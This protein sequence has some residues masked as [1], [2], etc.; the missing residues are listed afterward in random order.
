M[1]RLL[2]IGLT[3]SIGTGKSTVAQLLRQKGIPVIDADAL[4][5][6]LQRRGQP[7]W[8]AVWRL[9]G[10][11]YLDADGELLRRKLGRYVFEHPRAREQLNRAIHPLV[12]SRIAEQL[13]DY[14]REG[15]TAVVVDVPL[16]FEAGWEASF[17][18]IWVVAAPLPVQ[19]ARLMR[20]DGLSE[21][22]AEARILAQWPLEEK[23]RR[24]DRVL[25][26]SGS[27][28]QLRD[29]VE[30]AWREVEA[31]VGGG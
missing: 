6:A 29:E 10:W 19:R 28:Q 21:E 4:A 2:R 8:L 16:L 18:Q 17:D 11:A 30:Q 13:E 25:D 24:A 14:R 20:R 27:L 5:R 7:G 31:E 22:E 3:G 9:F 15:K 1:T 23:C 26:N 12:Q